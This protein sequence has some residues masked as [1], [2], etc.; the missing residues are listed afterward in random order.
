M[1]QSQANFLLNIN[2]I[3]SDLSEN[4]IVEILKSMTTIDSVELYE[5]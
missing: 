3:L 1:M 5:I 2:W 4:L